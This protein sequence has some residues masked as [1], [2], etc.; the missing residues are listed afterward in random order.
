MPLI[1]PERPAIGTG[2]EA[3]VVSDSGHGI[4]A[5]YSG[6]VHYIS[7]KNILDILLEIE[8]DSIKERNF[9]RS[10]IDY[11]KQYISVNGSKFEYFDKQIQSRDYL[12]KL[13]KI[14]DYTEL[15]ITPI[16]LDKI[17]KVGGFEDKQVVL[18][19]LKKS[20]HLNCEADRYTRKRQLEKG[21][22]TTVHVIKIPN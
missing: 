7:N 12:G 22:T 19:E 13:N 4:Q 2:L 16:A 15:V 5:K 6:F 9:N 21:I 8:K 10:A 18:K 1:L 17:L 14:D 3:R 20:G 11:I